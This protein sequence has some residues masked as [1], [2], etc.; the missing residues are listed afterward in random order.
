MKEGDAPIFTYQSLY[1]S[2]GSPGLL[3]VR[4]K[5]CK[6]KIFMRITSYIY[7]KLTKLNTF[8]FIIIYDSKNSYETLQWRIC[9]T[10]P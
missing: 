2:H 3:D 4:L 8:D 7:K 1:C 10:M 5:E 9:L 6:G